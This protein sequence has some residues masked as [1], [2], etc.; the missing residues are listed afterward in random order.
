M[1]AKFLVRVVGKDGKH[2]FP[3]LAFT[4]RILLKQGKCSVVSTKPLTIKRNDKDGI[5]FI[6]KRKIK[7]FCATFFWLSIVYLEVF[8][9]RITQSERMYSDESIIVDIMK[10]VCIS[11][12]LLA[13]ILYVCRRSPFARRTKQR[14]NLRKFMIDY[15]VI[16]WYNISIATRNASLVVIALPVRRVV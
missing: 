13:G 3:C 2:L 1:K 14:F 12:V 11:A 7:L 10:L 16:L 6:T 15:L 4:A 9:M 8:L 5:H